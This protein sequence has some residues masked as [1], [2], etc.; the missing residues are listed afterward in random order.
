MAHSQASEGKPLIPCGTCTRSFKSAAV[1]ATNL[2]Q[3]S[4]MSTGHQPTCVPS[5]PTSKHVNRKIDIALLPFLSLLYLLN[6]LDRSNVGNA[7]TQG[8]S[9]S[10]IADHSG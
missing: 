6:G 7:E 8:M 2:V 4:T 1:A 10:R 3:S 5:E 9:R